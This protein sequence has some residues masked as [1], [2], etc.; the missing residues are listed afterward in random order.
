MTLDNG[1]RIVLMI[2]IGF[3]TTLVYVLC[4]FLAYFT[5][6]FRQVMTEKS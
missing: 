3:V 6:V 2:L 4:V 5:R 1:K